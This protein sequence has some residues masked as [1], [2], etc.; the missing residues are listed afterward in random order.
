[1]LTAPQTPMIRSHN[2]ATYRHSLVSASFPEVPEEVFKH[3][4][5]ENKTEI[6]LVPNRCPTKRTTRKAMEMGVI[7]ELTEGALTAIPPTAEVMETAGVKTPSA[8][9]RAVPKSA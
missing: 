7:S 8:I 3:S 4:L 1:M 9:V 5:G 6:P 2:N